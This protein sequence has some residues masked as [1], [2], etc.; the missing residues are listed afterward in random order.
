MKRKGATTRNRAGRSLAMP[1]Q[2]RAAINEAARKL[3]GIDVLWAHAGT[4]GPGGVESLDIAEYEKAIALN[5]TSA[6]LAAGEVVSHMRKRGGGSLI[7]TASVSGLVGLDVQPDLF[8]RQVR[9]RRADQVAG[10]RA[11]RRTASASTWCVP[12][13]ADTPMKIGFTGRSGDPAEAAAN[14]AR[15][16]ATVP[17]GRLCKR[18]RSRSRRSVA[19][20][21]RRL[22]RDRRR[23][24][25]RRW[26]HLPITPWGIPFSP[27]RSTR[28]VIPKTIPLKPS[29]KKLARMLA[30]GL[31]AFDRHAGGGRGSVAKGQLR[32]SSDKYS[33]SKTL[34][35]NIESMCPRDRMALSLKPC[36]S[37]GKSAD[38][39]TPGAEFIDLA[40]IP[41]GPFTAPAANGIA[42]IGCEG[43]GRDELARV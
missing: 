18:R 21:R 4:P 11:S 28:R 22:V 39:P 26:I 9:R 41:T 6:V 25:H 16:L 36:T 8:G 31:R 14:E 27:H 42:L 13:L 23:A 33:L 12:G 32:R 34:R 40:P 10:A 17:M 7:F 35:T 29:S 24:A 43:H 1:T 2:A 37:G 15:L 3:G 30:A 19:R 5:V 38:G 20:L